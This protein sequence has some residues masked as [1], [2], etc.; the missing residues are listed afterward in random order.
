MQQELLG[1]RNQNDGLDELFTT[2]GESDFSLDESSDYVP[3]QVLSVV[4]SSSDSDG[5]RRKKIS[6]RPKFSATMCKRQLLER[7]A[8][9]RIPRS[10]TQ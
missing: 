10:V 8:P 6:K 5:Y 3:S 9:A 7:S 1:L 4:E 2:D